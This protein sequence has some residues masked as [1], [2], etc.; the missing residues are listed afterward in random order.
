MY[1]RKKNSKCAETELIRTVTV[2]NELGLHARAAARIVK[3]VK[4]AR[5]DVI[6]EKDGEY[7][8]ASSILDILTLN[9]PRGSTIT[10]KVNSPEDKSVLESIEQLIKNKF[11]EA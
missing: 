6:I 8:D 10:I 2:E 4:K 3:V 9:C 7:A 5:G 11:G 1:V